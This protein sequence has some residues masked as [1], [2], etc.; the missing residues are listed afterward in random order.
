MEDH[1]AWG[2]GRGS[3]ITKIWGGMLREYITPLSY[4]ILQIDWRPAI[5]CKTVK[6]VWSSYGESDQTERQNKNVKTDVR[7]EV[8]GEW[9][10]KKKEIGADNC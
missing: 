6:G 10:K 2:K 8:L 4:C 3:G 7:Q 9:F 1:S 5:I